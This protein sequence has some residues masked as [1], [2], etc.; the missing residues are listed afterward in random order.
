[1]PQE[2]DNLG[3]NELEDNLPQVDKVPQSNKSKRKLLRELHREDRKLNK[4]LGK[5]KNRLR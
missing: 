2:S 4:Q 5:L 1:M 3:R